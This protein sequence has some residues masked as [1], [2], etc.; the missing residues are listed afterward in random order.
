MGWQIISL[1]SFQV[2]IDKKMSADKLNAI[3]KAINLEF[4][5]SNKLIAFVETMEFCFDCSIPLPT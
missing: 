5:N 3:Q 1:N 2:T 4:L